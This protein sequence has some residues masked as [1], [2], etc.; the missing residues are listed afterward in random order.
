[1]GSADPGARGSAELSEPQ[2]AAG[3][4]VAPGWPRP[5]RLTTAAD[6]Q[7]TIVTEPARSQ[8]S[9]VTSHGFDTA[10][11]VA[12]YSQDGYTFGPIANASPGT[13]GYRKPDRKP[14]CGGRRYGDATAHL[15]TGTTYREWDIKPF[16]PGGRGAERIVVAAGGRSFYTP[17]HYV[18]FYEIRS[19]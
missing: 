18:S 19:S 14:W 11:I 10:P 13:L 2:R 3:N 7:R 9:F 17:D 15:P 4:E 5:P 12:G 8:A 16:Q 1:M 6:P